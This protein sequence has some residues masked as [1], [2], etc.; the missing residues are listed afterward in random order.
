MRKPLSTRTQLILYYL[1][2]SVLVTCLFALLIYFSTTSALKASETQVVEESVDKGGQAIELYIDKLKAFT[3]LLAG[4]PDVY[5]Y[6]EKESEVDRNGVL[7]LIE[8]LKASD[9]NLLTVIVV[10]S[11]GRIVS[12]ES[13]LDMHTSTNMMQEDWYVDAINHNSM[14]VLTSI[15]RQT[16][17]MDQS[18]WVISIGQEVKSSQGETLGLV[19]ID[20]SYKAIS[21]LIQGVSLGNT[22]YAFILDSNRS[23]VYHSNPENF[24]STGSLETLIEASSLPEGF[25]SKSNLLNKHYPILG[26]EWTLFSFSS[27]DRLS[28]VNGHLVRTL[29]MILAILLVFSLGIGWMIATR[30]SLPIYRLIDAMKTNR[31]QEA[32]VAPIPH[33][34]LE[35]DQLRL[36]YNE[37]NIRLNQLLQNIKENELYLREAELD[38]LFSQ[39]NPHF[40]YNTLDTIIWMAEFKDTEKVVSLTKAL[41]NFFRLSLS[42]GDQLIPLAR[43]VSH[44]AEYL[45]IQKERYEEVLNYVFDLPVELEHGLVPRFILQP[46]VENAI[47][48]GIKPKGSPGLIK[49]SAKILDETTLEITVSDDGVGETK[50]TTESVRLGGIGLSNVRKRI[51]LIYGEDFGLD[52]SSVPNEGFKVTI[53]MPLKFE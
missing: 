37:M 49:I 39:I 51:Q 35:I 23:L 16:F 1:G 44:V 53:R 6:L 26:T 38:S 42:K 14:P 33:A 3:S 2:T 18:T 21:D 8:L 43:E 5:A 30:F 17:T 45:I 29:M 32:L 48:H 19:I 13:K 25:D 46:L 15:R 9:S 34:S 20:V 24:V 47:Y 10:S 41:A 50:K 40:L 36:Q 31:G 27:L 4:A 22:G 11:D 28:V 52:T 12:N 7:S